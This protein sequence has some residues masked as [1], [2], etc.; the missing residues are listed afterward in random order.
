MQYPAGLLSP[1]GRGRGFKNLRF[2]ETNPNIFSAFFNVSLLFIETYAVCRSVCRWVRFGKTNPFSGVRWGRLPRKLHRGVSS[3]SASSKSGFVSVQRSQ[4]VGSVWVWL[5]GRT[6]AARRAAPTRARN[7]R[8]A[9]SRWVQIR[10]T[11]I[12]THLSGLHSGGIC[13][14]VTGVRGFQQTPPCRG[15]GSRGGCDPI[16]YLFWWLAEWVHI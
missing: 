6:R 11:K 3:D 2:C 9:S 14:S 16:R 5:P 1:K 13:C 12:N 10:L 8:S 4:I 7:A 15:G